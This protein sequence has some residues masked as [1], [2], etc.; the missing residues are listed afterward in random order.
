MS[1]RLRAIMVAVDYTD[2]LRITLPYNIHHF[3]ELC[4]VTDPKSM[5]GV[6]RVVQD[7]KLATRSACDILICKTEVFYEQGAKFNKWAALEQALD[8]FGREG[9]M[10]V[11]DGDVLWPKNAA[12]WLDSLLP[13]YLYGAERRMWVAWPAL[14]EP[15]CGIRG[16][17]ISEGV[18]SAS[19]PY[20]LP[21][22]SDWSLFPLHRNRKEFAGYTQIFHATDPVLGVPP[23]HE[24]DWVHAG[25]AD[26]FF[27]EKWLAERKIRLPFEVLHLGPAGLNWYGRATALADGSLPP[28]SE[29]R[30]KACEQIWVERRRLLASGKDYRETMRGERL[31]GGG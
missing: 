7:T 24:T 25:G 6:R 30:R 13:G 18:L 31:G 14:P 8:H 22:E 21:F 26:S 27:Q 16:E 20:W 28:L 19:S 29:E 9:W 2:L 23:W 4:I 3:S 1:N 17:T 15:A 10:C 11:M 5:E 12:A